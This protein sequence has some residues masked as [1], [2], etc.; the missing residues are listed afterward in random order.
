MVAPVAS[1]QVLPIMLI[2]NA[3][4][5]CL[6]STTR[7]AAPGRNATRRRSF[8]SA[9]LENQARG[10]LVLALCPGPPPVCGEDLAETNASSRDDLSINHDYRD[11]RPCAAA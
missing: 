11:R 2:R 7:T 4:A 3:A 6:A 1:V 8:I 5:D 10:T 9:W